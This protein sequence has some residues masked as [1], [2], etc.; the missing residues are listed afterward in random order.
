MNALGVVMKVLAAAAVIAGVVFVVIMYGEKILAFVR[1]LLAK[2]N[3]T[4][5]ECDESDFVNESDLE[6]GDIVAGDQD[7]EG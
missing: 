5:G 4:V 6:E 7:F 3:I 1:K 2:I